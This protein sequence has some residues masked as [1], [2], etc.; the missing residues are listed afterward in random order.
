MTLRGPTRSASAAEG[1]APSTEMR[2][3]GAKHGVWMVCAWDAHDMCMVCAWHVH[4]ALHC[5]HSVSTW[6]TSHHAQ[7]PRTCPH[8]Q[9]GTGA[10]PS[11]AHAFMCDACVMYMCMCHACAMSTFMC[12]CRAMHVP[13]PCMC[14]CMCACIAKQPPTSAALSEKLSPASMRGSKVIFAPASETQYAPTNTAYVHHIPSGITQCM[15]SVLT[16]VVHHAPCIMHHAHAPCTRTMHDARRTT[17][18]ARCACTCTCTMHH[19]SRT[20]TMQ[21]R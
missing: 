5:M 10:R 9:A 19:A 18:D 13:W 7:S 11:A 3:C 14:M 16:A 6:Y 12:M 15:H 2:D 17:H 4:A 1:A 21:C 20:R 8:R